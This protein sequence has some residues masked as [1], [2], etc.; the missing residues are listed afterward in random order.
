MFSPVLR[1]YLHAEEKETRRHVICC[2]CATV[3]GREPC[4]Y[5][6]GV[7]GN[8]CLY[9]CAFVIHAHGHG[10]LL[11]RYFNYCSKQLG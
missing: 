7:V 5:K 1:D 4:A 8:N 11:H 9:C 6:L 3:C 10:W 2:H